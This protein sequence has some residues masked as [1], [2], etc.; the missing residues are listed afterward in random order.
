MFVRAVVDQGTH[1]QAVLLPQQ[2][3]MHG[4]GGVAVVMVINKDDVV[5]PRPV[6]AEK[7]VGDQWVVTQGVAA[8]DRV[9]VQ[10]IMKAAPGA[11]VKPVPYQPAAAAGAAAPAQAH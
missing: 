5:E 10:G 4:Q 8:G 1:A 2:A 6:K 3:V 9:M 7:A 11:K